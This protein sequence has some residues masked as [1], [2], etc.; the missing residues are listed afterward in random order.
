MGVEMK[1]LDGEHHQN[2]ELKAKVVTEIVDKI[3][4]TFDQVSKGAHQKK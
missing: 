4:F 3:K 1:R 2:K